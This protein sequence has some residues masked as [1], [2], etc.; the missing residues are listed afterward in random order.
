MGFSSLAQ[1]ICMELSGNTDQKSEYSVR[2]RLL[3]SIKFSV[4]HIFR[5]EYMNNRK[6]AR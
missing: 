2:L 4:I 6:T 3:F 1:Q 5:V